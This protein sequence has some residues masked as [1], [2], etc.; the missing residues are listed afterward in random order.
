MP[1]DPPDR[2]RSREDERWK[3]APP[4]SPSS[5]VSKAYAPPGIEVGAQADSKGKSGF[6]PGEATGTA[7]KAGERNISIQWIDVWVGGS[8]SSRFAVK[9][10]PDNGLEVVCEQASYKKAYAG[11]GLVNTQTTPV[12]PVGTRGKV[13]ARDTAT[14]ETREQPWIWY[15]MGGWSGGPGLW[16][17]LKRLVWKPKT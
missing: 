8:K 15:N 3:E 5:E 6:K 1:S 11:T 16:E 17:T 4:P 10:A 13:T 9:T 2:Q 14:G 7:G 12:A